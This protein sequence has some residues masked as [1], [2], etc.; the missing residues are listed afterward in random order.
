MNRQITEI[1]SRLFAENVNPQ[2]AYLLGFLWAD[3]CIYTKRKYSYLIQITI[4]SNDMEYLFPI[5]NSVGEWNYNRYKPKNT[6]WKEK[7]SAA[8]YSKTLTNYLLTNGFDNKENPHSILDTLPEKIHK[9]F[10]RGLFDGDGNVGL[11]TKS[12]ACSITS[13]Y[14]QNWEALEDLCNKLQVK[15][16]IQRR[17]NKKRGKQSNFGISN[18]ADIEKFLTYIYD[19]YKIDHIG[20]RRK[21]DIFLRI[22]DK[23]NKYKEKRTSKYK[24][25]SY[26]KK[27]NKWQ[28]N[29]RIDGIDKVFYGFK[30]EKDAL[31]FLNMLTNNQKWEHQLLDAPI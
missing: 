16:F 21:Y 7:T 15:Y 9:Y 1:D 30:T 2:S 22:C 18:R 17:I 11:T 8:I 31:E 29:K 3:G 13:S 23:N 5:L 24:G 14:N 10:W 26:I 25:I 28:V 12:Y 6:K 4:T 27:R 19:G 20:F